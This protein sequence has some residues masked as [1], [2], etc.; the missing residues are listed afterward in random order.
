LRLGRGAKRR[1][2]LGVP[3]PGDPPEQPPVEGPAKHGASE[4]HLPRRIVQRRKPRAHKVPIGRGEVLGHP[5]RQPPLRCQ[6]GATSRSNVR[7]QHLLDQ[8]RDPLRPATER[9]EHRGRNLVRAEGQ[10]SHRSDLIL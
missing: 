10:A 5:A 6:G 2:D 9:A 3:D 1:Q 4:H 8:E 7:A